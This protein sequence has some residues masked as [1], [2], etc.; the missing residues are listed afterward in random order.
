M[1]REKPCAIKRSETIKM[2]IKG[3][4]KKKTCSQIVGLSPFVQSYK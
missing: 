4:S 2:F 1:F 3:K